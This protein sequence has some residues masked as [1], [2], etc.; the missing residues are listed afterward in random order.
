MFNGGERFHR[1]NPRACPEKV[2]TVSGTTYVGQITSF[3]VSGLTISTDSGS[4]DIAA[5]DIAELHSG[6]AF[7]YNI[8]NYGN[9]EAKMSLTPTCIHA[10]AAVTKDS[11][12]GRRVKKLIIVG[13]ALTIVA[14]AI[15]VPV[16]IAA[17]HHHHNNQ[18]NYVI[19]NLLATKQ[20]A[21]PQP[22]L[23]AAMHM[24]TPQQL[25]Q[26]YLLNLQQSSSGSSNSLST[27]SFNVPVPVPSTTSTTATVLGTGSTS[28]SGSGFY[29]FP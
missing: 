29:L 13:M 25:G 20:Q 16:A 12:E 23:P 6:L 7:K 22:I 9:A 28:T 4:H 24:P 17:S 1:I 18:N 19:A 8:S 11:H 26:T 15:T 14:V 21:V 10:V 2:I 5:N 3:K 27:H